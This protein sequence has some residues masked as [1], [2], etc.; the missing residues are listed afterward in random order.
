MALFKLAMMLA[1]HWKLSVRTMA[2]VARQKWANKWVC[3]SLEKR[4]SCRR[5]RMRTFD[6]F[7]PC[8]I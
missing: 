7:L 5:R 3:S 6:P 2:E 8:G 1:S 4:S